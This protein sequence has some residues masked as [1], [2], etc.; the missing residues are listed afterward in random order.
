MGAIIATH[1]P[2]VYRPPMPGEHRVRNAVRVLLLDEQDRLLLF[3]SARRGWW[4]PP[5]GGVGER[6]DVRA[7]AARE[8]LEE[9]GLREF[10]LG[11]EVWRR[12]HSFTWR[13]VHYDQRERWFVARVPAF[14]P[15]LGGLSDDE[16]DDLAEWR[17]WAL[18]ELAATKD[19]LVPST[20][21]ARLRELLEHGPPEAPF[22]VG[23]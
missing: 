4:Q 9:T 17:W 14:E 12:R 21:A 3:R 11:A 13:D 2:G 1:E 10:E 19:T 8:I 23:P 5:G 18:D 20:L 15:D 16:R 6:E 22:D 7:A